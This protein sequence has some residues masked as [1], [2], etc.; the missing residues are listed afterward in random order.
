[1][2]KKPII[3]FLSTKENKIN[4]DESKLEAKLALAESR[5]V[6][7]GF[8]KKVT[9]G[10]VDRFRRVVGL[11]FLSKKNKPVHFKI[12]NHHLVSKII[13]Q[14]E[15]VKKYPEVRQAR[16][17]HFSGTWQNSLSLLVAFNRTNYKCLRRRARL[18][19]RKGSRV[20]YDN[21][22]VC[23][24]VP[25]MTSEINFEMSETQDEE[26]ES[27]MNYFVR[28]S[29]NGESIG[30]CVNNEDE[31]KKKMPQRMFKI[32]CPIDEFTTLMRQNVTLPSYQA[33]CANEE[34]EEKEV[35]IDLW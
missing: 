4:P 20:E 22:P 27:K 31:Y 19:G 25:K 10:F 2:A 24:D 28:V 3:E 34:Q 29:Y 13:H 11:E 23:F 7:E 33:V 21:D 32:Y 35:D 9:P 18:D 5:Y 12:M 15:L 26:D 17:S 16:F 8:P 1:M 30:L 6:D 14:M